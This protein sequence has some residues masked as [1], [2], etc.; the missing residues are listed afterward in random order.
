M[1][2][3]ITDWTNSS[4][5]LDTYAFLLGLG[6]QP[7]GI[8]HLGAHTCEEKDEYNLAGVPDEKIVWIEGNKDLC[9]KNIARG[10]PNVY[11]ALISDREK[12]VVFHITNN[13][14]SSSLFPLHA[15]KNYYP[16]IVE[17]EAR[18]GKAISMKTFFQENNLNPKMYNMWCLDIQGGEFD[19]LKGAEDILD[20]VDI[21]F[22]EIN[23]EK[24]YEDIPL[25]DTL[26]SFLKEK[27][28]ELTHAK[29]WKNCWGDALFVRRS[30]LDT[31]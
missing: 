12:D 24:M 30:Y 7:K 11:N 27:G 9:E 17:A 2:P 8:L 14:A 18:S 1:K 20:N 10:I 15:H 25:S 23:I 22:T 4:L 6:L 29:V 28:F 26:I 21:L 19:A 31:A 16:Q 3:V 13:Y 5:F